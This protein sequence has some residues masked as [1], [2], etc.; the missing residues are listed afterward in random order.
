VNDLASAGEMPSFRQTGGA[1]MMLGITS[2]TYR[3]AVGGGHLDALGLIERVAGHGLGL[4]QFL[5]NLPIADLPDDELR[6]LGAAARDRGVALMVG[7]SGL[8]PHQLRRQV[9]VA[10]LVG[11]GQLRATVVGGVAAAEAT[12]REALPSLRA[13][14][15][16]LALENHSDARSDELAELVRRIG[17]PRVAVCLD[18]LNSIAVLEGPA[19]TVGKLAPFAASVHLKDG[20]AV[21]AGTGWRIVGTALGEGQVDLSGLLR[22]V[23]ATGRRPPLLFEMWQDRVTDEDATLAAE[24]DWVTRSVAC[25]K[26][27][28]AV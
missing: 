13:A 24:E 28:A 21:K 6:A 26:R 10:G 5:D 8:E 16:T 14:G 17:D 7:M 11:A 18:F 4:L 2:Y 23:W 3:W 27:L 19:E 25:L 22:V 15:V 20:A 9:E 12:I 1:E